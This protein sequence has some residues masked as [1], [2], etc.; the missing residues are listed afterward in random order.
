MVTRF[1][2]GGTEFRFPADERYL[3]PFKCSDP[4]W[5]PP[6]LLVSR[7]FGESGWEMKFDTHLYL[8]LRLGMSGALPLTPL[9]AFVT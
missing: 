1:L 5:G 3:L 6:N 7:Y 2:A 4:L 8:V 9:C